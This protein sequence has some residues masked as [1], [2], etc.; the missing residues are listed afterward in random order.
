MTRTPSATLRCLFLCMAL[1]CQFGCPGTAGHPP[2]ALEVSDDGG[3]L[4]VADLAMPSLPNELI[5]RDFMDRPVLSR[6]SAAGPAVLQPLGTGGLSYSG[7]VTVAADGRRMAYVLYD[8][9]WKIML[10][11]RGDKQPR[12]AVTLSGSGARVGQPALSP[13]GSR[14]V[15][16]TFN[17]M[18]NAWELRHCKAD[19]SDEA[20]IAVLFS[21]PASLQPCDSGPR[22]S[23]NG[24]QV[25]FSNRTGPVAEGALFLYDLQAQTQREVYRAPVGS[26]LCRPAWSHDG[27]RA[28]VVE[29]RGTQSQL[30]VIDLETGKANALVQVGDRRAQPQWSPDDRELVY[31][32][33]L[34]A[35]L[36]LYTVLRKVVVLTGEVTHLAD[37][38][39]GTAGDIET[40]HPQW[41]P[42]GR[43]IAFVRFKGS[44]ELAVM[45]SAGGAAQHLIFLNTGFAAGYPRWLPLPWN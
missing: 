21:L 20:F 39:G 23:R 30:L 29:T 9:G 13:D 11:E 3:G 44:A 25:L 17:Y 10:L 33:A 26:Q 14:L 37:L 4:P 42:D 22:W 5:Y 7:Q 1:S 45:P 8:Q 36:I 19:G 40:G 27:A 18:N 6:F 12:L 16:V 32:D 35:D 15:Y 41:S 31:V 38:F 2:D 34:P 24:Q 28:A 43:W